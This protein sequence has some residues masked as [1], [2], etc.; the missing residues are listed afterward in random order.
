MSNELAVQHLR[1]EHHQIHLLKQL[2]CVVFNNLCQIKKKKKKRLV[3]G[4]AEV[5]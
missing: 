5:Y 3:L 4:I 1:A 2:E